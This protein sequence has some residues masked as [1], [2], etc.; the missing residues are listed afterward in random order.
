M[1]RITETVGL[2]WSVKD[3]D[4]E[5]MDKLLSEAQEEA[6]KALLE[7][8]EKFNKWCESVVRDVELID[9]LFTEIVMLKEEGVI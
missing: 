1:T 6:E 4:K 8:M 2:D 3:Y 7:E 9:A 5:A